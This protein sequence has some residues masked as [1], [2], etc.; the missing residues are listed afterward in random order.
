MNELLKKKKKMKDSPLVHTEFLPDLKSYPLLLDTN[1]FIESNRHPDQFANLIQHLKS[2]TNSLFTLEVIKKEFLAGVRTKTDLITLE[3]FFKQMIN[4]VITDMNSF[5][6]NLYTVTKLY[7]NYHKISLEDFLITCHMLSNKNTILLTKN[8]KDFPRSI[9]D[10]TGFII[11]EYD[12][13]I[14]IYGLY[15]LNDNKINTALT[16]FEKTL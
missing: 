7:R 16:N 15:K 11:V 12:A 9:F 1:F 6:Q 10:R 3:N 8:H 5:S 4:N 13:E 14:Q 2:N